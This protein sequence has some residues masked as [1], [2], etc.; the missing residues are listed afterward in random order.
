MLFGYLAGVRYITT[1]IKEPCG[2]PDDMH[3]VTQKY[4]DKAKS[5][6]HSYTFYYASEL[7]NGYDK[8]KRKWKKAKK[9]AHHIEK[10]DCTKY[11][12]DKDDY[13]IGTDEYKCLKG[14]IGP[15]KHL[16]SEYLYCWD[17]DDF[18]DKGRNFRLIM[19]F[20]S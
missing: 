18:Y 19:F 16:M 14:I 1:P 11:A 7:I 3:W 20:D 13:I 2:V 6:G 12:Y 5:Y 8:M 17:D 15:M 10:E 9:K 4:I